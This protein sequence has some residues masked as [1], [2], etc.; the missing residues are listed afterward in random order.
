MCEYTIKSK[1][2]VPPY[3]NINYTYTTGA[4]QPSPPQTYKNK[5]HNRFCLLTQYFSC[6]V[7]FHLCTHLIFNRCRRAT[8]LIWFFILPQAILT[9]LPLY[10]QFHYATALQRPST[11][12]AFC[13][14][15]VMVGFSLCQ[16]RSVLA[17]NKSQPL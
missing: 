4:F 16:S 12:A 6:K 3:K 5:L 9:M 8:L 7:Y 11:I 17:F 13:P 15:V 10:S 2:C 14:Y 1:E